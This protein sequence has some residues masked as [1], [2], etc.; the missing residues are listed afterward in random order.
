M[1]D[2]KR[3]IIIGDIHG[4]IDELKSLV[5]KIA[6]TSD[7][8]LYFIGDLID[9]GPDSVAVVKYVFELSKV[10]KT[11]LI[12]GNHEEKFLRYLHNKAH[13]VKALEQMKITTDFQ[14][15]EQELTSEELDFLKSSYYTYT[16]AENNLLLLHGGITSNCKLNLK[17]NYQYNV[18]SPK[19]FKGLDLITKTRYIDA[20]G[21]FV[22][23]GQETDE[24][25]FWADV[26]SGDFGTVIFG[27]QPFMQETPK[28]FP[29][30]I[31]IDTACVFGGVL[32]A[33]IVSETTTF[34]SVSANDVYAQ[35]KN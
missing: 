22:S 16:I 11:I 19:E 10:N 8:E 6:I 7:D 17:T 27:H 5:T 12:L 29:H 18:H 33:L 9:K 26:Y 28:I 24:T 21:K 14:V 23:F 34:I 1:Q 31:G 20:A 3:K 15:L 25:P 35:I 32:T 4:C 13:N 2:T 30:A